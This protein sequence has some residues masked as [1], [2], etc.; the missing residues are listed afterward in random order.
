[1]GN[2]DR[3]SVFG[4]KPYANAISHLQITDHCNPRSFL[5][6]GKIPKFEPL[7]Y[8]G[9]CKQYAFYHE[10]ECNNDPP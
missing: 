10:H 8:C 1:M 5:T 2:S 3:I 7:L 4:P 9:F 6:L